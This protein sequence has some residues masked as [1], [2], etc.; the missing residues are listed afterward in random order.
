MTPEIE[1]AVVLV[2]SAAVIVGGGW[3]GWWL[4]DRVSRALLKREVLRRI[5]EMEQ[6][7]CEP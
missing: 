1:D 6:G 7:D 4:A 5:R 2:L 3:F